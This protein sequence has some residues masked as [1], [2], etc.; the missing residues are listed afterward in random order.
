MKIGAI[1]QARMGSTRLPGKIMK[2]I[3]G[4]TVL[5]HVIERTNQ[6]KLIDEIVIATTVHERDNIIVDKAMNC[7]VKVFRGSEN[8]VLSRYYF[9]AKQN[10]I[11]LVL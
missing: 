5:E 1:I 6:S 8:D 9:A 2:E 10:L 3:Q 4:K 11:D 7:G